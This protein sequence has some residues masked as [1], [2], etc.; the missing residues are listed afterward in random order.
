[1]RYVVIIGVSSAH[2]L[3]ILAHRRIWKL[4]LTPSSGLAEEVDCVGLHDE[5]GG[6]WLFALLQGRLRDRNESRGLVFETVVLPRQAQA[7]AA[8][9][10]KRK[11]G[12]PN[13]WSFFTAGNEAMAALQRGL[14]M[15]V[16]ADPLH[17]EGASAAAAGGAGVVQ[18]E[19]IVQ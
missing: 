1:M 14:Q 13:G 5:I 18:S 16:A 6:A 7:S 8:K 15:A 19:E 2:A 11:E 3:F 17:A 9:W 10:R 12:D 4:T